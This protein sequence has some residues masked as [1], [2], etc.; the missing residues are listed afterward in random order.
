[1]LIIS[2]MKRPT[3]PKREVLFELSDVARSMRTYIDQRAGE[4]GMTR[5]QWGAL[6][7]LERQ[8]GMTQAELADGLEI[9]PITLVRLIDRLCQA[10]LVER[11]PHPRDRRANRLYLT[12]KGHATL[13]RLM[14]LG[15]EISGDILATMS[16]AD[17]LDLLRKLLLIKR[18]I[19]LAAG[20]REVGASGSTAPATARTAASDRGTRDGHQRIHDAALVRV[21]GPQGALLAH[22]ADGDPAGAGARRRRPPLSLQRPLRVDRQRLCRRPEGADHAGGVGQGRQHRRGRGPAPLPRRRAARD[23][24]RALPL[25]RPGGR[26]PARAHQVRVRDPQELGAEPRQADRARAPD[27]GRQR[28]RVRTQDLAAQ[29]P[30]QHAGRPRQVE[31]GARRLQGAARAAPAAGGDG[32]QSAARQPRPRH[33]AVS[34]VRGGDRR[35][36]S[37]PARPCQHR[38]ARAHRRHRH[39]GDEHPD[40][41]LPHRRHGRVQHHRHRQRLDRRQPQGDRPHARASPA[42]P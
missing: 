37:R 10:G 18:N 39:A 16:D 11:R 35:P 4:H 20:K 31:D 30:H 22:D 27:S 29:Q 13:A 41:P 15:R 12:D 40:G 8:E 32:A 14:P 21:C 36:R 23:R 7:R 2:L 17:I 38:P 26:G 25:R 5:A 3:N 24:S 6:V 34:P 28:G 33:R 42:S 9:Q 19:R 1:M